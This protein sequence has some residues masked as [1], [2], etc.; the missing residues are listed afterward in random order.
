[1]P[2]PSSV[3]V[4]RPIQVVTAQDILLTGHID[5][6]ECHLSEIVPELVIISAGL[7]A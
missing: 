3:T 2:V 4:T 6:V 5:T 7:R 1:M